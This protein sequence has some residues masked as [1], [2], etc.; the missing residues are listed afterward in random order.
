MQNNYETIPK[1]FLNTKCNKFDKLSNFGRIQTFPSK[2]NV[3]S[4][5]QPGHSGE[6]DDGVRQRDPARRDGKEWGRIDEMAKAGKGIEGSEKPA[7]ARA[8]HAAL[9]SGAQP[10]GASS[11]P[12]NSKPGAT[13]Q[14]TRT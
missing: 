4:L 12:S 6:G 14:L 10:G 11:K 5:A 8:D 2:Q 9:S 13:T 1:L 3:P 7:Q